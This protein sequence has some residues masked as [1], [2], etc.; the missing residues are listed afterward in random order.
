MKTVTVP[1]LITPG[2]IADQVGKSLQRVQYIL[3]TRPHIRPVAKAGRIRLY[4][5][6]AIEQV[7]EA[8]S[9]IERRFPQGGNQLTF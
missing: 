8:L 2:V 9:G 1:K 3:A 4:E 7:R 6:K 5:S